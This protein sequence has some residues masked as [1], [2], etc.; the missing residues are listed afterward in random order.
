M[1]LLLVF[2]RR[3]LDYDNEI[4]DGCCNPEADSI[5]Q[6]THEAGGRLAG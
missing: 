6:M 1:L 3:L 2:F 5:A 4:E